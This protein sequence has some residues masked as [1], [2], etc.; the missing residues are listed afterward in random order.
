MKKG[1]VVPKRDYEKM[2][3]S[4][5]RLKQE[6][7]LLRDQLQAIK[8]NPQLREQPGNQKKLKKL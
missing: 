4:Y 2:V 8:T 1:Y 3:T 7:Q 6:N 5:D